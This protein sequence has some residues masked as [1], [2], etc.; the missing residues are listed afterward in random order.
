VR[1]QPA[2]LDRAGLESCVGSPF[3]PGIECGIM[4]AQR[5]SYD[6]PFRIA[7]TLPPGGLTAHMAVPWQADFL[8]CGRLW[9]PGQRPNVV[10]RDGEW[11]DWTP[12]GYQYLDMVEN[13][14]RLGFIV[15]D[16]DAYVER[17]R[18]LDVPVA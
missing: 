2:A 17:E 9:W 16:G 3:Y 4:I 12:P 14:S 8:A 5:A 10:R 15:R 1:D 11:Q 13:W 6:G 18:S 7:A